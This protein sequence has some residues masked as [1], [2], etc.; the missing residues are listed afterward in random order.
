MAEIEF[1]HTLRQA[2]HNGINLFLGAG[3][4]VLAKDAKGQQI[5]TGNQLCIELQEAFG[6]TYL[7][8]L[9][10]PQLITVLESQKKSELYAFLKSRFTVCDFNERYY[11]LDGEN[12]TI[13]SI[14]TTNIDDLVQKIFLPSHRKYINDI[15]LHGPSYNDRD[16]IDF[17]PLHGQISND[18][19]PLIF[20]NLWC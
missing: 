12:I 11:H 7:N 1:E 3:F 19:S 16:C 8:N 15:T 13:K 2:L 5:P 9:S 20:S 10:L 14:F 17:V 4:S 6:M 18:E